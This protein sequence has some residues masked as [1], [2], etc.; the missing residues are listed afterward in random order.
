MPARPAAAPSIPYTE[1]DPSSPYER[2]AVILRTQILNGEIQVGL[3]LPSM[4]QLAAA[5]DCS[6]STAQRAVKLLND[7]GLVELNSG[8]RTL[9]KRIAVA[10]ASTFASSPDIAAN[11]AE[12]HTSQPQAL[13]L[14]VQ[15]LGKSIGKFRAEADPGNTA[16][17]RQLLLGAIRRRGGDLAD[18]ADYE[19]TVRLAGSTDLVTTFVATR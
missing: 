12:Q 7:W 15:L 3:P 5:H 6:V 18:I 17:L 8:R 4:K 1:F 10:G 13:D 19:L 11:T 14:E 9:V 2:I 16:D